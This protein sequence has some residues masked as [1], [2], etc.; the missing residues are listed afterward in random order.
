MS[1]DKNK[2]EVR[3]HAVLKKFDGDDQTKAPIEIIEVDI[4]NGKEVSRKV[5][6]KEDTTDGTH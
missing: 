1:D 4:V 5:T 6:R 3:E 2:V